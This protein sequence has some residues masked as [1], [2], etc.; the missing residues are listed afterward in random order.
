MK[1]IFA[2]AGLLA[3]ATGALAQGAAPPAA[4]LPQDKHE[5]ITVSADVYTDAARAKDKLGKANPLPVGIL[6]VE[7]FFKNDTTVPVK[8]DM[9]TIQFDVR[10]GS[11]HQD[12][13][14]L[15]PVEVA[16]AVAHPKGPSDPHVRRF[17]IGVNIPK[18]DKRDKILQALKPLILDGDIIPPNGTIHGFL[19]FDVGRDMPSMADSSLY[20]PDLSVATTKKPLMFFEVMLAKPNIAQQ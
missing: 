13:D 20:V 6:P 18:D 14:W 15:D 4:A 7:V 3:A 19:F 10:S 1:A 12:I 9:D 5:G 17:P 2:I 11:Q 16:T 8:L